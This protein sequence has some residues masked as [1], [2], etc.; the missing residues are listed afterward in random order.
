[1][2]SK[3]G[4]ATRDTSR[5]IIA[6][7]TVAGLV[8]VAAVIP[9]V[10]GL[11]PGNSLLP[12][13]GGDANSAGDGG[14]GSAGDAL[15]RALQGRQAGQSGSGGGE[16]GMVGGLFDQLQ[17]RGSLSDGQP[18]QSGTDG[19]ASRFGA[20]NPGQETGVGSTSNPLSESLR[21]QSATPHFVVRSSQPSYWRTGAF[22]RYTGQGWAERGSATRRTWPLETTVEDAETTPITQEYTLLQSATALPAAWQPT[23]VPGEL[24]QRVRV[25]RNRGLRVSSPMPENASYTVVSRAPTRDPE[26]L[27]N[28]DGDYPPRIERRYTQL[29]PSTPDRVR[30]FTAD[31]VADE[32]TAYDRAVAIER[33]L[34]ENKN[35]S[36]NAT[37]SG[38][39]IADSFLFE[40]E[41][42][43][44]E[45]FATTMVVMLRSEGIPARYAVGY[46]T[47]QPRGNDTYLV[48]SMNAHAWVEVYFQDVGW[49][50]FDP[51]PG[52]NRLAT[53][54]QLLERAVEN[55]N[56]STEQ[57]VRQLLEESDDSPR[58]PGDSEF[59]GDGPGGSGGPGSRSGDAENSTTDPSDA[60]NHTESG[61]PNETLAPEPGTA[62]RISLRSDPVPGQRVGVQVTEGG[63]PVEGVA[64]TFNGDRV[65]VTNRSGLVTGRVPYASQLVINVTRVA[66]GGGDAGAIPPPDGRQYRFASA[67][68][69]AAVDT[70]ASRQSGENESA[71]TSRTFE[72]PTAV[73][74]AVDGEV[75]PG[76]TVTVRGVIQNRSIPG[77]TV[78]VDGERVGRIDQSGRLQLRLPERENAT[79]AIRRGDASGNRTLR[80]ADVTVTVSGFALP[81]RGVTVTVTDRGERVAGATVEPAGGGQSVTTGPDGRASLSLP[82]R[83]S[84][85]LR[86]TTPA[87][88]SRTHPVRLRYATAGVVLV[89]VLSL[90]GALVLLRNRASAAGR[91]LTDQLV[92]LAW[93]LSGAFVTLLVGIAAWGE[94]LLTRLPLVT[95]RLATRV[96]K[97][98]ATLA[99]AIRA[100]DLGALRAAI[101]GPRELLS[102]LVA[103]LR[104]LFAGFDASP[105]TSSGADG[106]AEPP[107][108]GST[109]GGAGESSDAAR[110]QIRRAWRDLRARLS[111]SDYRTKTAAELS[112]IAVEEGHPQRPVRTITGAVQ[113]IEYGRRDP[114]VYL[115]DVES[116]VRQ[117]ERVWDE[118]GPDEDEDAEDAAAAV[119]DGGDDA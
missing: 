87:G 22:G 57:V 59:P 64:V 109:L 48:R 33:W 32:A 41:R 24:G 88:I 62:Y 8:L 91:S 7:L 10:G 111:V 114:S 83:P 75:A 72:V 113:A 36:L 3:A 67:T 65:G 29:P 69:S 47:G 45:Y 74:V 4:S 110:E 21:N 112:R 81:G 119:A 63:S 96:R 18:G 61:S 51:T 73:T 93:W 70:A 20:L 95:R 5:T 53:E 108:P 27:R 99:A 118:D 28:A 71:G 12:G 44:C 107:G 76:G 2:S 97:W 92:A 50:R 101:P 105:S 85:A 60:Y 16:S 14:G 103:A 66:D 34:A 78:S 42:G 25:T 23:N 77:A 17:E 37:H 68:R 1:M 35:Y 6:L 79:I 55:G 11:A 90:V 38:D 26:V 56:A 94:R 31:L 82:L 89:T 54:A 117:L 15:Q 40:M 9:A 30:A 39:D 115:E 102:R 58:G 13:G 98:L 104:A 46:S 19:Q 43:Y 80:L 116:A 86:A 100:Q 84:V 52:G 106:M 49:V